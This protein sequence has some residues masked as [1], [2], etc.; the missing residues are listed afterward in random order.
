MPLYIIYKENGDY[1][2]DEI[3][4]GQVNVYIADEACK[5]GNYIYIKADGREEAKQRGGEVLIRRENPN[6]KK[7]KRTRAFLRT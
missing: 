1:K 6:I 5:S 7:K 2:A 3:K 4:E